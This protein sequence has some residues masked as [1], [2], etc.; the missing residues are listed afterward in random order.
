MRGSWQFV[1]FIVKHI[2]IYTYEANESRDIGQG[3]GIFALSAGMKEG[4]TEDLQKNIQMESGNSAIT[5]D[6]TEVQPVAQGVVGFIILL[7]N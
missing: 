5:L 3:L 7:F 6:F 2:S 1:P 4:F